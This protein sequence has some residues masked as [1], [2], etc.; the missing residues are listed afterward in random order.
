MH[1]FAHRS[2]LALLVACG[3][4]SVALVAFDPGFA[5]LLDYFAASPGPWA[6]L[7][8]QHRHF[9]L[10][11][12]GASLILSAFVPALRPAALGAS[13]LSKV[14]YLALALATVSQPG[15]LAPVAWL[16]AALVL[17]LISAAALLAREAWQEARWHG[18]LPAGGLR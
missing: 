9:L 11:L 3:L 10:G 1:D 12:L 2:A 18:M 5:D 17:G 16:E 8:T 13:I 15:A 6:V 4:L 7:Q 14:A